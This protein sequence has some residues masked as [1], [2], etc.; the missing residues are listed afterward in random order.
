MMGPDSNPGVNVRAIQ[1][2]LRVCD[3]RVSVDYTMKVSMIEVYNETLRDLLCD[4][5]TSKQQQLTI[6]M[7][8]KQLVVTDLSEESVQTADDIKKIMAKGVCRFLKC[9]LLFIYIQP[10]TTSVHRCKI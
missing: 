2:L 9:C 7:K 4:A 3:E 10:Q 5:Q 8:G 1:E 6:Q